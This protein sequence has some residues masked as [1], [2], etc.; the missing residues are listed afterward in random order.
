MKTYGLIILR[1]EIHAHCKAIVTKLIQAKGF[2]PKLVCYTAPFLN[3]SA[4]T[5]TE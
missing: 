5:G 1:K 3:L 2:M 4:R